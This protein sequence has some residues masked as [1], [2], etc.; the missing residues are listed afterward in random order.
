M[1]SNTGAWEEQGAVCDDTFLPFEYNDATGAQQLFDVSEAACARFGFFH[2]YR[3]ATPRG[4]ALVIGVREGALWMHVDGEKG[5]SAFPGEYEA[6][7][8]LGITQCDDAPSVYHE[9]KE[10]DFHVKR[11]EHVLPG[12][13]EQRTHLVLQNENGPCPLLALTN[14][15]LARGDIT[16]S[17]KEGISL[18]VTQQEILN[19][20][21]DRMLQVASSAANQEEAVMEVSA[22]VPDIAKLNSGLDINVG[23]NGIEDYEPVGAVNVFRLCGVR[24]MHGWVADSAQR[25]VLGG[26]RYNEL[27]SWALAHDD[28]AEASVREHATKARAF[29]DETRSQLTQTGLAQLRAGVR[30]GEVVVLF[31]NNHFATITRRQGAL[32]SMV[33]DV[34][35]ERE[36][37]IVWELLSDV[38]GARSE[39]FNGEFIGN[40]SSKRREVLE[41]LVLMGYARHDATAAV[42]A[43]TTGKVVDDETV[44]AALNWLTEHAMTHN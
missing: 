44:T 1:T 21:S 24:L 4:G 37:N 17:P 5:A 35:Y 9:D 20:L 39:F 42:D 6:L 3:V 31:R 14:A 28:A 11:V 43:V 34:G 18:I 33:T 16:L 27:I 29:L 2:G 41:T 23:F 40:E 10:G 30:E 36:R 19:K 7:L 8:A 38:R 15:L 12:S 25:E 32:Y 26:M 22:L 13:F